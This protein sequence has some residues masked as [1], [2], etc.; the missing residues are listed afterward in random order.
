KAVGESDPN[1]HDQVGVPDHCLGI[2]MYTYRG[3]IPNSANESTRQNYFP[4]LYEYGTRRLELASGNNFGL[5]GRTQA[6]NYLT[7]EVKPWHNNPNPADDPYEWGFDIYS[8]HNGPTTS[9]GKGETQVNSRI[10]QI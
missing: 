2:Q 8:D 7:A 1:A 5:G 10:D 6:R 9:S 3:L 4:V